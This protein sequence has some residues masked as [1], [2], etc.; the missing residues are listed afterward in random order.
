VDAAGNLSVDGMTVTV[1]LAG[2]DPVN[3][4]RLQVSAM[5]SSGQSR[6]GH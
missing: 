3:I 6:F 4:K 2:T 1:G 5:V